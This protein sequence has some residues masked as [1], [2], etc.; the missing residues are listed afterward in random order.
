MKVLRTMEMDKEGTLRFLLQNGFNEKI[1][2]QIEPITGGSFKFLSQ[3]QGLHSQYRDNIDIMKTILKTNVD[4]Y[5]QE[6][7]DT[8][9]NAAPER[10]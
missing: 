4:E 1:A 2:K 9:I 6:K 10:K 8:V 5:L 7:Y 3:V